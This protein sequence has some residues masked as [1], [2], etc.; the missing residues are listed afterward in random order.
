MIDASGDIGVSEPPPG[1]S[2]WRIGIAP[3][4]AKAPPSRYLL[5]RNAAVTTSG[6]AFQFVEIAD[7]RYSH[8]V[9]PST[10]LGLSHRSSVTVV[11]GDCMAA[12]SLATAA[13]VLGPK[14]GMELI[15][16]TPG[17]A[18]LFVVARDGEAEAIASRRL[19]EFEIPGV[20]D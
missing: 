9:D 14:Q 11:A 8:I 12:D 13:C 10:G 16:K 7:E 3:L 6:D 17:A 18:G 5:L 2:G 19:K 15:E 1:A 4:D 20:S